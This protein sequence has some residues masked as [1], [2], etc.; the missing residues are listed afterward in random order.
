MLKRLRA[1]GFHASIVLAA[2]MSTKTDIQIPLTTGFHTHKD[3]LML[4]Q[5]ML[6]NGT[7]PTTMVLVTIW[8]TLMV[9]HGELRTEVMGVERPMVCQRLIAGVVLILMR[10]VGPIQPHIGSLAREAWAMH[11]QKIQLNGTMPMEM[12]EAI[13]HLVQLQ[14]FAHLNREPRSAQVRAETDGVAQILMETDGQTSVMP[15]SMNRLNGEIPMATV[16]VMN[17]METRL[18]HA[19]LSEVHPFST[20]SVA[21][22]PMATVGRTQPMIGIHIHLG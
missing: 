10:T 18:M 14:M 2:E 7:I 15:S 4:S 22:I 20:V 11:G 13:I 6:R 19:Q 17:P 8:S 12:D 16:M 9:L 3:L 21:E 1:D 5:T